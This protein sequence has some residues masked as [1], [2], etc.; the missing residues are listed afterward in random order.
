GAP[1]ADPQ[2]AIASRGLQRTPL[3]PLLRERVPKAGEGWCRQLARCARLRLRSALCTP[4]LPSSGAARHLLPQG[5]GQL[6]GDDAGWLSCRAPSVLSLSLS[7]RERVPK[8]GE[9]WCRQPAA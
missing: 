4:K 2:P 8:A 5:E 7:R 9:G 6:W 3:L 1:A